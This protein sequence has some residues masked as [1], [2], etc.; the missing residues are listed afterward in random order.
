MEDLTEARERKQPK[1]EGVST[2]YLPLRSASF[3][4]DESFLMSFFTLSSVVLAYK[5][6]RCYITIAL[7][8]Q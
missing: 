5:L 1:G 2:F 7:N 4:I 8:A 6:T 3:R